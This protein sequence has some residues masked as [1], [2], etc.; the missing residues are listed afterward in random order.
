MPTEI[1][2]LCLC[3]E[4]VVVVVAVM[5]ISGREEEAAV[6]FSSLLRLRSDSR[7]QSALMAGIMLMVHMELAEASES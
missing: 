5:A 3:L 7:G 2:C 1:Y 6:R 4:V